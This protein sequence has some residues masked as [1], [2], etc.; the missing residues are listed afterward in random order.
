MLPLQW[1]LAS[2][3]YKYALKKRAWASYLRFTLSE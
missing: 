3:K 2:W 1:R